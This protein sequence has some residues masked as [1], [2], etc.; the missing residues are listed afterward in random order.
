MLA[1]SPCG[2]ETFT[3]VMISLKRPSDD[4]VKANILAIEAHPRSKRLRIAFT[5]GLHFLK[6]ERAGLVLSNGIFISAKLGVKYAN[7]LKIFY[8]NKFVVVLFDKILLVVD[9][10]P[11]LFL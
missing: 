7:Y 6:N 10:V 8:Y 3:A 9:V 4:C 1:P 2:K 11:E 5:S